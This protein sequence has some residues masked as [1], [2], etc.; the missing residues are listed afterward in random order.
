MYCSLPFPLSDCALALLFCDLA[1]A[2]LAVIE[3]RSGF[4]YQCVLNKRLG[5]VP[6][7]VSSN[8]PPAAEYLRAPFRETAD[9]TG[10]VRGD[11]NTPENGTV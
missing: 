10:A 8:H 1:V 4:A 7:V 3:D 11:L 6:V 5:R 9:R 2:P